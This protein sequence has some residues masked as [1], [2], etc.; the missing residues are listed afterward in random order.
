MV[1]EVRKIVLSLEEVQC[2]FEGYQR[3]TPDFLPKGVI[4]DCQTSDDG[5]VLTVEQ[6][7]GGALQNSQIVCKGLNVL[8]PIIRFCIENNIMLPRDG[9]K[10]IIVS[11]DSVTMHIELDL[12]TDLPSSLNPMRISH[13][14]GLPE[15]QQEKFVALGGGHN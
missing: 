11:K 9:K 5:V 7:Y 13:L 14:K 3:I 2:A 1:Q 8:K 4:A 12:Y 15:I 10:T 6:A